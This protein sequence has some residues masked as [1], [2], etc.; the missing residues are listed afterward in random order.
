V[1][2]SSSF[3]LTSWDQYSRVSKQLQRQT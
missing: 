3:I 1:L 2:S